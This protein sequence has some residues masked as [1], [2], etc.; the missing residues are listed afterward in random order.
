M[1]RSPI[2]IAT[3]FVAILA[4]PLRAQQQ[5]TTGAIIE[6]FPIIVYDTDIGLGGGAKMMVRNQ[7]GARES[8]DITVFNSTKGERWYRLAVSLPDGELRHGTRYPLAVDLVFDYDKMIS[9]N[10]YGIGNESRFEDRETYTKEPIDLSIAF[11]RGLSPV[12]VA[13]LGLRWRVVGNSGLDPAGRFQ[14][15][16]DADGR[17]AAT[18]LFG[19]LRYD[20]RNSTVN[21]S[22]GAVLEGSY[23][24]AM[25]GLGGTITFSKYGAT[26]QGYVPV[27]F[28]DLVLAGRFAFVSVEG[29]DVPPQ[30]LVSVGGNGTLRGSTVDRYMD[31]TAAI[32]NGELRFPIYRRLAGVGGI[33]L[34]RVWGSTK[35]M[36]IA[37]WHMNP[38]AGLR[39]VM[40]TF[41]VRLDVGFGQET[42]GIYFNFGQLF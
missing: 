6:L 2:L 8:F 17:M 41:I 1:L 37:A 42:T 30:F 4:A 5:D 20:S 22:S 26:I 15:V 31:R 16:P 25:D 21:P 12:L 18:S 7:L 32:I 40:E 24:S 38:T 11:S 3:I 35:Q 14:G 10:F 34:G 36:G 13:Q 23:E 9:S 39:F 27:I 29:D 33:D 19:I 28:P